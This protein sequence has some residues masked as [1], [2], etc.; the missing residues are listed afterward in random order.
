M[1]LYKKSELKVR[2]QNPRLAKA[3]ITDSLNKISNS[4]E[5]SFDIFLSHRFIDKDDI[6]PIVEDLQKEGLSVY[7]DW[8][9]D[10]GLDRGKV[11][12]KTAELLK[13]RM[14][15]CKALIFASTLNSSSS[16]WMPWELGF[17][18]ALTNKVAILP[19]VD[20]SHVSDKFE[21]QEYLG[22]YPYIDRDG[23][24]VLFV[25]DSS[26]VYINLKSW[27]SGIKPY[28]RHT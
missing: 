2:S 7:V 28:K 13:K 27:M 23:N 11:T 1:S 10:P 8:Q 21:G 22:I 25:N 6:L 16:K 12:K 9:T 4:T 5:M 14:K 18:D 19:I 20:D 17:M 24:Q 15:Q 26:D 3:M